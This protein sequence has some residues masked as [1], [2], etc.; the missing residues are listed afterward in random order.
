MYIIKRC[1]V[2]D[3]EIHVHEFH[4]GKRILLIIKNACQHIDRC[5]QHP[6]PV[7]RKTLNRYLVSNY[8]H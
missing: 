6:Y 5:D 1:K 3:H 4:I 2:C 7:D 8:S